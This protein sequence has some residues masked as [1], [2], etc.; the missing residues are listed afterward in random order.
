RAERSILVENY[1]ADIFN[2]AGWS[3]NPQGS[4]ADSLPDMLI[5]RN[6]TKYAIE[7]KIAPEAR[8]DRILPIWAQ[9]YLQTKYVAQNDEKPL[10]IIVTPRISRNLTK[11]LLDHAAKYAPDAAIGIL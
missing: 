10:P 8:G 6:G 9:A 3:V 5:T 4:V 1:L 7:I 2:Q 11:Q